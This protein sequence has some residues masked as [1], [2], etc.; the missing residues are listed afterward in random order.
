MSK[1]GPI[2]TVRSSRWATLS[3]A[4]VM[5]R[6]TSAP[7]AG[8]RTGTTAIQLFKMS[9][10]TSCGKGTRVEGRALP[11]VELKIADDV[12]ILVKGPNI[13]DGYHINADA[14]VGVVENALYIG[15]ADA[16]YWLI[17]G[18][19]RISSMVRSTPD[20]V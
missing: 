16:S 8:T 10:C 17:G 3:P 1:A 15:V 11:G 6:W 13:F 5:W 12:E 2:F 7:A 14:S 18:S 20:V 4:R 9:S 19:P